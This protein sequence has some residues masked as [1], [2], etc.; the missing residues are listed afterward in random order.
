MRRFV[1]TLLLLLEPAR[2][3]LEAS[4]VLS[5]IAYRGTPA[6]IELGSH[7]IVAVVCA[8]AALAF[9]NGA[10]DAA[11]VVTFA[12]VLAVT[13]AVQSVYWSFLPDDTRPGDEV[14]VALIA[15]VIG[16]I[17]MLLARRRQAG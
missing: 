14:Y 6:T 8:G 4:R 9:W 1:V 2:F 13:R 3:A 10:P 5:T 15:L 12:A 7:G 16:G 11:R 17:V